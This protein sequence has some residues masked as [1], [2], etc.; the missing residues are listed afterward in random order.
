MAF[1]A[2]AEILQH[3]LGP[4]I[5]LGEQHAVLVAHVEFA[6]QALEDLVGFGQ[7]LVAGAVA[8]DQIG[9]GVEPQ[10]VDPEIEPEP[11]DL[12]I[13]RNTCGLSKFKSG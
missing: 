10:R 7:V 6:A 8:L 11:H 5:G 9:N 3:V 4:L 1:V 12:T 2:G 13:A